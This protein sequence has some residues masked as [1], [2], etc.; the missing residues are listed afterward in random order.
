MSGETR[1]RS[2]AE[3]D[4]CHF[5]SPRFPHPVE[6]ARW[7]EAGL[8]RFDT[9]ND[10]IRLTDKGRSAANVVLPLLGRVA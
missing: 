1:I 4:G 10:C 2:L 5:R 7:Y 8:I 9:D 6:M 3:A